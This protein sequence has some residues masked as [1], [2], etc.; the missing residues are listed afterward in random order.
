MASAK[1]QLVGLVLAFVVIGGVAYYTYSVA[2][3]LAQR[4]AILQS[5]VSRL[6][7]DISNIQSAVATSGIIESN[8]TKLIA[9]MQ[10]VLTSDQKQL[11]LL[12]AE[13]G[14][15]QV[16][17]ATMAA[18]IAVQLSN[19]SSSIHNLQNS[20][21]TVSPPI[22]LRTTGT[23]LASFVERSDE[24]TYLRLTVAGGGSIVEAAIGTQPFNAS[25]AGNSVAWKAVGNGVAVD[26]NH[27]FWP[28]VLENSPGGTNAIEFEQAAGHQEVA[29]VSNGNRTVVG[30]Q[31]NPLLV[32]TFKI[33]IVT[34]G[35]EVAFYI[36]GFNVA[37]I[38]KGVPQ[39]EFFIEGAEVKSLA[40]A[41]GV[42][43]LDVYG[44]LLGQN[45]SP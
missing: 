21:H 33:V 27:W 15:L 43:M 8:D 20:L 34:P 44:G 32:H 5:E 38:S 39:G 18:R 23:A 13:L 1:I 19:L 26:N 22:F 28:M 30:V 25:I 6:Q 35:K 37:T 31:W 29:V 16:G 9:A 14:S 3:A 24:T 40:T 10:A 42:A 11:S 7:S 12:R 4:N 41:P 36:D 17:N 45:P 2:G